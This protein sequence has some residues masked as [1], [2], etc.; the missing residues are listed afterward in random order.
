MAIFYP[1]VM[2]GMFF[3]TVTVCMVVGAHVFTVVVPIED[4]CCS[5]APAENRKLME[6]AEMAMCGT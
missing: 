4:S 6:E 1:V 5:V 2:A 3:I